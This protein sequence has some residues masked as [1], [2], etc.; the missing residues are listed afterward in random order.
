M[1]KL[2]RDIHTRQI[3]IRTIR[4]ETLFTNLFLTAL[5]VAASLHLAFFL[6][7]RIDK[8]R[9]NYPNLILPP[10]TV[11]AA[12]HPLE[13]SNQYSTTEYEAETLARKNSFEPLPSPITIPPIALRGP[14]SFIPAEIPINDLSLFNVLETE[15]LLTEQFPITVLVPMPRLR[16][17]I[18]GPLK[19][20]AYETQKLPVFE[21]TLALPL[22]QI[23]E[24]RYLFDVIVENLSG[25]IIWYE[26]RGE[27]PQEV[28]ALLLAL[29]FKSS[30]QGFFTRGEIEITVTEKGSTND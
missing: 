16:L 8:G 20:I 17:H 5:A 21:E 19:E 18:S 29:D 6:I 25:K 9:Q 7:F 10:V 4:G 30:E 22:D 27:V 2:E 11:H 3:S 1:L 14:A 26:K 28:E 15:Y 12:P 23:K 24:S 13:P